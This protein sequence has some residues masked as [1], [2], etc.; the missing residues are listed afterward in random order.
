M[1]EKSDKKRV[2]K[3]YFDESAN[4]SHKI[5]VNRSNNKSGHG[6]GRSQKPRRRIRFVMVFIDVFV[7]ALIVFVFYITNYSLHT[8]SS[9]SR[10][11][12]QPVGSAAEGTSSMD[13]GIT[14]CVLPTQATSEAGHSSDPIPWREKFADQFTSG[15]VEKTDTS[16]QDANI[17]VRIEK[18]QQNNVT[19]FFAD[20][21]IA[22]IQYLKTAFAKQSDVMGEREPTNAVAN[23]NNAI[24]AI[25]G[26]LCLDN[27]G[28]VIRNGQLYRDETYA[29]ALVM[30]N[31]GSMQTFSADQLDM[32]TIKSNGAWQVWTF[33]PMLLNNGQPMTEFNST[34]RKAN[35]RTAVGYYE[36]GHYCF[37]VV[38][39]RQPGYS[40]GMTLQALSQFFFDQ[41]CKVAFNLDGGQSS[42]MV[43]M[44]N[45]INQPYNG[46]RS[47]SDIIYIAD[48]ERRCK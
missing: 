32:N 25:N 40:E 4:S 13:A 17:N 6:E 34:L 11:P 23:E 30:N 19:Y 20:I 21:Y 28:P 47:T 42:E 41:G 46:G 10:L 24:L 18:V 38:D 39:G 15:A 2:S 22:D 7:A 8:E 27:N 31:D 9:G 37:L 44:G 36:P 45:V 14:G 12:N 43:F 3:F 26:D 29:D 33:G 5:P 16:Y 48:D 35:P 1:N